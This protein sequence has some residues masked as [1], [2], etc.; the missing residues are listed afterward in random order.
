MIYKYSTRQ[1]LKKFINSISEFKRQLII[2]IILMVIS[3]ALL[4]YAPKLLGKVLN[5]FLDVYVGLKP[6]D[7]GDVLG[8]LVDII[9]IYVAGLLIQIPINRIMSKI[10]EKNN[11]NLR[12]RLYEKLDTLPFDRFNC[13]YSGSIVAR[14]NN[15]VPNIK[16]FVSK[17]VVKFITDGL[18]ILFTVLMLLSIDVKLSLIFLCFIPVYSFLVYYS[19]IKTKNYYKQHQMDLGQIVGILGEYLPRRVMFHSFGVKK[20][21]ENQVKYYN[22]K[23]KESF[24]K[25]RFYSE[26]FNPVNFLII[27]FLQIGL[28]V[29]AGYMMFYG[30]IDIGTF[31]SFVLYIQLFKRPILT[32][33]YT[34]N[35]IKLAFASLDRIFEILDLDDDADDGEKLVE[36][37]LKG[38]IEFRDVSFNNLSDFN[39]II[40]SSE[41]VNLVGNSNDLMDLLLVLKAPDSGNIYLDNEDITQFNLKSYRSVFGVCLEEDWI[42]NGSVEENIVCGRK[43]ISKEDVINVSKM[44][45]LDGIVERF[46]DKYETQ[47]SGDFPNFSSGEAKLICLARALIANPKILIL[48]YSDYLSSDLLK[49]ISCDKTTIFL[50]PNELDD[51]LVDKVVQI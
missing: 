13:E 36:S 50:S 21:L 12:V 44:I 22:D 19:Y 27:N 6:F 49:K 33:G 26:A 8:K 2:A 1:L 4:T 3:I 35:S 31:S 40:S 15:D 41:N 10:S 47:L 7:A 39:L 42:I 23:Q 32:M 51:D 28:Y 37:N 18:I 45:G 30:S 43:N 29:V 46:P 38:E 14:F 20:Y 34:L 48:S 11:Y 17:T 16:I 9:L 25:S 5:R 24:F